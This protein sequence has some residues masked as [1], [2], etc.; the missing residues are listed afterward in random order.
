MMLV[1]ARLLVNIYHAN[2]STSV[3]TL[4]TPPFLS[5]LS[6]KRLAILVGMGMLFI[7]PDVIKFTKQKLSGSKGSP[8]S[9]G[10]G[11]FFGAAGAIGGGAL[12]GVGKYGSI[13]HGLSFAKD[14]K[15]IGRFLGGSGSAGAHKSSIKSQ[16]DSTT[17]S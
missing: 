15:Y 13:M 5:N 11:A 8:I 16:P 7:I 10:L 4:W 3:G 1:T 9:F 14:N 6:A 2:S 12:G 17:F